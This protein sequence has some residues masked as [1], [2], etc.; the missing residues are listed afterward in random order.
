MTCSGAETCTGWTWE[1]SEWK[2][3]WKSITSLQEERHGIWEM[4]DAPVVG[5]GDD[6]SVLAPV[7]DRRTL[8]LINVRTGTVTTLG[9]KVRLDPTSYRRD[10][11][12]AS[13][14]IGRAHV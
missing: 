5:S 14:E 12:V 9:E 1:S 7:A 3:Q 4:R 6:M 2:Q 11:F 13:D 10:V 8:Q